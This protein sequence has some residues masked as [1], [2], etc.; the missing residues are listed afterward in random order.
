MN[1]DEIVKEYSTFDMT[2]GVEKLLR[3]RQ[4][5]SVLIVQITK[6]IADLEEASKDATATRKLEVATSELSFE[7][8]W[9]ERKNRAILACE[10]EI[11]S[12]SQIEGSLKAYRIKFEGMKELSNSMSSYLNK[13]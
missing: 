1:L 13:M 12:E 4:N 5:L 11:L 8:A 10:T 7:G 2:D 3:I 9:A 6:V